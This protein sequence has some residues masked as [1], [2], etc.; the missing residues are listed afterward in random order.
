LLLLLLLQSN[1]FLLKLNIEK[2]LLLNLSILLNVL[3]QGQVGLMI[4]A[5]RGRRS[6]IIQVGDVLLL[7]LIL[8][9]IQCCLCS[10][11]GG[12]RF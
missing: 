1:G 3:F 2:D 9:L 4:D 12:L 11:Y 6:D 5:A 7:F 8:L 10:K